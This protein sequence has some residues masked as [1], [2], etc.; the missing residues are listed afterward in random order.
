[1]KR[2]LVLIALTTLGISACDDGTVEPLMET[3]TP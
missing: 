2:T 1:M 3:L